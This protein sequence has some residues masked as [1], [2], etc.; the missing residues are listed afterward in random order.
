MPRF[1]S[2][3]IQSEVAERRPWCAFTAPPEVMAPAYSKNFSVSVVLPASG[4]LMIAN[5]LRRAASL[6]TSS[7]IPSKL[8]LALS[9]GT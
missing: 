5:V 3:S 9:R 4:W 1:C 2:I 8:P 6:V 7:D